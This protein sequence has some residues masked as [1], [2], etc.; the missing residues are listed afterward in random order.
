MQI[1]QSPQRRKEQNKQQRSYLA[2]R[3]Y[4]LVDT[5]GHRVHCGTAVTSK[6]EYA[7]AN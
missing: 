4:V 6:K 3:P 7:M 5:T 2:V 1:M